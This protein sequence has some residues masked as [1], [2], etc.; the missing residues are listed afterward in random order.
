[1]KKI[2]LAATVLLAA[3]AWSCKK[4]EKVTDAVTIKTDETT[5]SVEG[6]VVSIA[7]NATVAWT[8]KSSQ[9]WVTISPASG[10]AGDATI[11]ASVLK[12]DTNDNRNAEI[13]ITAGT[14]KA[15]YNL[16]QSQKD[17]VE[18]PTKEFT[19]AAEGGVVEIPVSSNVD[20]TVLIPESVD[21]IKQTEPN[22]KGM[23]DDIIYLMVDETHLYIQDPETGVIEEDAIARTAKVTITDGTLKQEVEISQK[24]FY[25]YF[26]YAGDWAGLQWSFY[27]GAP[28]V[29]PQEGG[30]FVIDIN[31]N[32]GWRAFMSQYD[33]S[34]DAGVDIMD[35]GWCK[36]AFDTE[37]ST[38]TLTMQANDSYFPREDYLYSVGIIDEN[39]DESFGGLGWFQQAGIAVEGAAA[40]FEWSKTLAELGIP[41]AYNRLAYT[42]TGALL[43]SD[44]EKVH[45]INPA[46]G[47]YWK[48][49]TYPGITPTSICSDDA[50]NVIV[51]PN[52][53]ADMDWDAKPAKLISG[54]ELT[55]YYSSDPN[56]MSNS[57]KVPNTLYG[58]VGGI[59]ARGD[60]AEN[61]VISGVSGGSSSWFAYEVEN[62]E[63]QSSAAYGSA[64]NRGATGGTFWTPETG[65][66]ISVGNTLADGILFRAYQGDGGLRDLYYLAGA[67]VPNWTEAHVPVDIASS[68]SGSN[69]NQNNLAI[70]DYNGKRIIAY[71]QGFHFS[72]SSDAGIYVLDATD[73]NDVKPLVTINPAAD[74]EIPAD[75]LS[76]NSAD[77]LLH[78]TDEA[79]EL[80]VINSGKGIVGKYKIAIGE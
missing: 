78:P 5:V 36:L 2:L 71:T 38:I 69:E 43:I 45:A 48:A 27:D 65:A 72:Y 40:V 61:A 7:L 52:V 62:N 28:V 17:A 50:G 18:V 21:W 51:M 53:A 22:S 46:D 64:Q 23:I 25:P 8:A 41:A 80:F 57:F 44:G 30:T 70:V 76:Q 14:A 54:T 56:T 75:F 66:A 35:N 59:R 6:G 39:E 9:N 77:V 24:A 60:L 31:T 55:I 47:K 63:V 1:M 37:A 12:N 10:N 67:N 16:V 68:G 42:A 19:I 15:T 74:I 29:F 34:I 79:L 49:I 26:E 20:L 13:T 3:F 11:K 32:I 4:E 58:T 33:A 73:L